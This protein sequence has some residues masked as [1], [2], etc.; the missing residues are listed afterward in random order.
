MHYWKIYSKA[1]SQQRRETNCRTP[2]RQLEH[3][4]RRLR[5]HGHHEWQQLT[6]FA[7]E[8][9]I[10]EGWAGCACAGKRGGRGHKGTKNHLLPTQQTYP[11][12]RPID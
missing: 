4:V 6:S 5:H 8:G 11:H 7:I 3:L 1:P 2:Q 12:T 10:I 9:V